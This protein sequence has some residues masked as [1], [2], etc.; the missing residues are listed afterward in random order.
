MWWKSVQ[1]MKLAHQSIKGEVCLQV[2]G[3]ETAEVKKV[4]S[5]KY[6]D[7]CGL[8]GELHEIW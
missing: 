1:D 6:K 3:R 4:I 2:S 7:F 8:K 5:V